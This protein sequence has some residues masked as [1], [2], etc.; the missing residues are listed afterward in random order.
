MHAG[1]GHSHVSSFMSVLEVDGL[2]HH[3]MKKRE[4]EVGDHIKSVA[5]ASCAEALTEEVSILTEQNRFVCIF[6]IHVRKVLSSWLAVGWLF[7]CW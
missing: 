6:F 2:H 3:S 7:Y 5:T 4:I 1:V